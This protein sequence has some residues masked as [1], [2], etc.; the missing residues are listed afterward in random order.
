[1]SPPPPPPPPPPP[2]PPMSSVLPWPTPMS[3]PLPLLSPPQPIAATSK[4][5]S[6]ERIERLLVWRAHLMTLILDTYKPTGVCTVVTRLQR[7]R[8]CSAS[9]QYRGVRLSDSG[10]AGR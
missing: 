9:E 5:G 1:M 2:T 7:L 4:K 10:C 6:T 8:R 3:E